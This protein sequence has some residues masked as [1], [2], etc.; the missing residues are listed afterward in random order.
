MFSYYGDPYLPHRAVSVHYNIGYWNHN[1]KNQEVPLP[2]DTTF[3]ATKSSAKLDM[4]LAAI[5]PLSGS[6]DLSF[7]LYG[8]LFLSEPDGPVYSAE[9]YAVFTPSVRYR[10][11]DWLTVDAGMDLRIN[12]GERNRTSGAPII[13]SP[14]ADLN[15]YPP[16]KVH[17]GLHFNLTPHKKSFSLIDRDR[18]DVRKMVDFY[19]MIEEEKEKSKKSEEKLQN[20]HNERKTAEKEVKKIKKSLE[21]ED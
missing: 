6:F 7:E 10:P 16:W 19:D 8:W 5:I 17:I 4:A 9:D 11:M 21:G 14:M 2:N 20:L 1:E 15:N 3:T 18:P 13:D 12:P